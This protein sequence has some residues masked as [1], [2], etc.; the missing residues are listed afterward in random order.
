MQQQ[1]PGGGELKAELPQL[2][3]PGLT[4]D[5]LTLQ[6]AS[7][8]CW[9]SAELPQRAPGALSL[10]AA[11]GCPS[12][13][14]WGQQQGML[15]RWQW[16]A[17]A[18]TTQL[19]P[20]CN[21]LNG[22][23]HSS[24]FLGLQCLASTAPRQ[25]SATTQSYDTDLLGAFSLCFWGLLVYFSSQAA[26][27]MLFKWALGSFLWRFFFPRLHLASIPDSIK[28]NCSSGILPGVF[29]AAAWRNGKGIC[30]CL[31]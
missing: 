8:L 10:Q 13:R 7:G 3:S 12:P 30:C 2:H 20:D 19:V 11:A 28:A 4:C 1:S 21:Q 26:V 27:L 14:P 17:S 31:L 16:L 25:L 23:S 18:G 5:L 29:R 22:E 9:A 6:L 15:W 24:T